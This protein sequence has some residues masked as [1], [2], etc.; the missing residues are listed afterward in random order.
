MAELLERH[1]PSRAALVRRIHY[2]IGMH[3][4]RPVH[5]VHGYR[6]QE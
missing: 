3:D 2:T 5:G 4:I 6:W 1:H